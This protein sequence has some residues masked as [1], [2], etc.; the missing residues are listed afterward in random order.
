MAPKIWRGDHP[1]SHWLEAEPERFEFA[2]AVRLIELLYPDRAPAAT[3]A[4]AGAEAV[5]FRAGRSSAFP[6]AEL[7]AFTPSPEPGRPAT[8]GT[9]F[10]ALAGAFG[11]LPAP[12]TD[13]IQARRRHGDQAASDFLN[14]FEH[15]LIGLMLRGIRAHHPALQP[16]APHE[17]GFASLL[18]ALLGLGTPGLTL[19]LG[20]RAAPRL[21]VLGRGLLQH[22]GLLNQRPVSLHAIE[23]L[24]AGHFGVAVRG[25]PFRGCWHRL[26]P[27]D[28]TRLGRRGRNNGLGQAVLGQ[29][30]WDPAAGI[31][32]ELGPL[33]FATFQSFL[34]GGRAHPPLR[35][36]LGVALGGN[37][38]VAARLLL[39]APEVPPARL[40]RVTGATLGWTSW[41]G[42]R[43]GPAPA[44]VTLLL[45]EV[46]GE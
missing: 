1:L 24:L 20:R 25:V 41:L 9:R 30:L 5:R 40:G 36:M 42:R 35:R 19:S 27:G 2:Q 10:L 32:L 8:L 44:P 17:G 4:D 14:I 18:L 3:T 13:L 43:A 46:T 16:G 21:G 22:V 11:P 39:R 45:G 29:R 34:P 26:E 28:V 38:A 6:T 33:G 31:T 12:I 37:V 15:R 7:D 23:R